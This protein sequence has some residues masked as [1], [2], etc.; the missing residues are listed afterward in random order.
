[1]SGRG[2]SVRDLEATSQKILEETAFVWTDLATLPVD[3]GSEALA[4]RLEFSGPGRGWVELVTTQRL[5]RTIAANMLGLDDGEVEPGA[6]EQAAG[7]LLNILAGALVVQV[8]GSQE[9]CS[10]GIPEVRRVAAPAPPPGATTAT[11]LLSEEGEPFEL[12]IFV[13]REP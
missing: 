6:P 2:L 3:W 11:T 12:A 10:L 4:A 1:M 9:V 5:A 13:D 8:F 7:E